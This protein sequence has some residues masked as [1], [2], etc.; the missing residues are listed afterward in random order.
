MKKETPKTKANPKTGSKGLISRYKGHK[1]DT[2]ST[3]VQV[4]LLS[5]RIKELTEHLKEHKKDHDSRVGLLKMVNKRR[6]LLDY[7]RRNDEKKYKSL[8]AD[9]GLKK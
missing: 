3:S 9:I 7:L 2:G 4:V 5:D 8:I 1:D 6:R